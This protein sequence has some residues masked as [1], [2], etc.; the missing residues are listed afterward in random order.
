M[1]ESHTRAMTPDERRVLEG[2]LPPALWTAMSALWRRG[3]F[4]AEYGTRVRADL[5]AGVAEVR[6][7]HA[8]EAVR[9]EET[10]DEGSQYLVR[11]VDGRAVF[12]VG[13]D[14]YGCEEARRFPCTRFEI[15]QVPRSGH[16]LGTRCLGEYL[17]PAAVR[18]AFTD[19]EH[20]RGLVPDDGEVIDGGRYEALR[21]AAP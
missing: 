9:V 16:V 15:A 8:A 20:A 5:E 1:I 11:L 17:A 2:Q 6:V 10:E 7:F 19:R 21:R 18:P 3:A 13:Q 4:W 14:L 12:R